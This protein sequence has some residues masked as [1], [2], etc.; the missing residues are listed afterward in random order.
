MS[1]L[2]A[3][4]ARHSDG[5]SLLLYC[6][7]TSYSPPRYNAG[8]LIEA[9]LAHYQRYGNEKFLQPICKYVDLLCKVFGDQPG[10][11]RAYPG[12]SE[13]ELALLRLHKLTGDEKHLRLA[14]FFIEERGNHTGVDGMH[15]YQVEAKRRGEKQM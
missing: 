15:Y 8:H 5:Y 9:S 6:L 10:Q 14:T 2:K 4:T 13:I 7:L 12:H 3:P 1:F 11:M